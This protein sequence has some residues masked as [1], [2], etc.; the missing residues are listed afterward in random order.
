MTS[1]YR[2]RILSLMCNNLKN[3]VT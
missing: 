2:F 3:H 1:L